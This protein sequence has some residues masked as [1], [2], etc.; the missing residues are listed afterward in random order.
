GEPLGLERLREAAHAVAPFPLLALGGITRAHIPQVIKAGARGVAAI[1][2]FG[3]E[4]ELDAVV[5][6]L[7]ECGRE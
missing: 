3:D 4:S 5:N 7:K 6:E 2:L 1:R